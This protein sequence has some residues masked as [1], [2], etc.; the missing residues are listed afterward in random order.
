MTK[1]DYIKLVKLKNQ[2]R[3]EY[4]LLRDA[5]DSVGAMV[6]EE[7][8]IYSVNESVYN[9]YRDETNLNGHTLV[10]VNHYSA[11][12]I[13]GHY[14][15]DCFFYVKDKDTGEVLMNFPGHKATV[16]DIYGNEISKEEYL[17]HLELYNQC[18]S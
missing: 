4:R 8:E 5:V 10:S 18:K 17:K 16:P 14:T 6:D 15:F 13:N 3:K 2:K 11:I 1:T 12:L 9:S 7:I